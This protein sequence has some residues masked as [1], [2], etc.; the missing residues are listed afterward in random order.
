[1]TEAE[2]PAAPLLPML[3]TRRVK[4]TGTVCLCG[5]A[6]GL[7]H[8]R[9]EQLERDCDP[10]HRPFSVINSQIPGQ[11]SSTFGGA[12]L[13]QPID[14]SVVGTHCSRSSVTTPCLKTSQFQTTA[15]QTNFATVRPNSFRGLGFFTTVAHLAKVVPIRE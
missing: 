13:A 10:A 3:P 11:L 1:M 8:S 9:A 2:R 7:Q 6:P 5:P 15:T 14:P 12:V 4:C